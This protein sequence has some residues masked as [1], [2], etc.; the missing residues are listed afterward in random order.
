MYGT[1]NPVE[2]VASAELSEPIRQPAF[3]SL[4]VGTD[5]FVYDRGRGEFCRILLGSA[6]ANQM[7]LSSADLE[8]VK[9]HARG[10]LG[11]Q[12]RAHVRTPRD[13]ART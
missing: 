2:A 10:G 4:K 8:T 5:D 3:P 1:L 6:R 9:V 13:Q 7:D 11:A 12:H